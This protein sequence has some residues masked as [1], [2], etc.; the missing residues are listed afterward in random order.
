[1]LNIIIETVLLSFALGW[2]LG[3]VIAVHLMTIKNEE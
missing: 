1:M 3:A 2:V